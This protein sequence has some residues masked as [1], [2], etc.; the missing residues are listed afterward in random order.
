M[1][2]VARAKRVQEAKEALEHFE[3]RTVGLDRTTGLIEEERE[4]PLSS[5]ACFVGGT[6]ATVPCS[7]RLTVELEEATEAEQRR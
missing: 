3:E 2:A 4:C 7:V 5:I 1:T 6:D